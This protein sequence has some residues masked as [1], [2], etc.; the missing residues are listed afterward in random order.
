M[1]EPGWAI[2]DLRPCADTDCVGT[3]AL[4]HPPTIDAQQGEGPL[5]RIV[6]DVC[7]FDLQI[8]RPSPAALEHGREL[9]H[10]RG[11]EL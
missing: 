8:V 6:C 9:L 11:W 1:I 2:E 7:D 10:K 3:W 4:C 5:A